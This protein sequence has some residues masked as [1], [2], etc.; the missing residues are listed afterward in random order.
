M[1]IALDE[2]VSSFDS[3][4]RHLST[5]TL[6]TLDERATQ[7]TLAWNLLLLDPVNASDLTLVP[8]PGSGSGCGEPGVFVYSQ[9][10]MFNTTI[11]NGNLSDPNSRPVYRLRTNARGMRTDVWHI[12]E[13][14]GGEEELCGYDRKLLGSVILWPNGEKTKTSKYIRPSKSKPEG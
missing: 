13:E 9:D 8:K 7:N 1:I 4:S 3:D 14:D 10:S 12:R 6:G 2:K 11:F 5:T